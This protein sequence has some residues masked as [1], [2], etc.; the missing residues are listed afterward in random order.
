[1]FSL[2]TASEYIKCQRST[3]AW[4]FRCVCVGYEC[5]ISENVSTPP[6]SDTYL[7]GLKTLEQELAYLGGK[8][9]ATLVTE[10]HFSSPQ[11]II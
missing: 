7:L 10:N 1:M 4:G 6:F 5:C 8:A 2:E 9:A 3:V 11:G